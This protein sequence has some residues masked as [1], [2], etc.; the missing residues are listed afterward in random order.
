MI[1]TE[2]CI[3]HGFGFERFHCYYRTFIFSNL[4]NLEKFSAIINSFSAF[5][6]SPPSLFYR[7]CLFSAF[8]VLV[9]VGQ[10]AT[11]LHLSHLLFIIY[12]NKFPP[13]TTR[14]KTGWKS[15]FYAKSI[16]HGVKAVTSS[17]N[18]TIGIRYWV[19]SKPLKDK[20]GEGKFEWMFSFLFVD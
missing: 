5:F 3:L 1:Y 18:H 9:F 11:D 17:V 14:N 8:F 20:K 12:Y 13:E 7:Y 16:K 10:K 6:A 15:M 19:K 4:F 2:H